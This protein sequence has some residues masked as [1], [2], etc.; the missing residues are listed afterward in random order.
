MNKIWLIMLIS[1]ISTL[2]FRNPAGVLEAVTAG[3]RASVELS[4]RLVALYAFW[5]G[6]FALLEKT[7]ITRKFARLLRP[8]VKFL[9]PK[10]NDESN[11]FITLNIS[12]N[13]LGIG[14]AAT[15]MA[16]RAINSM[17][18]KSGKATINMIMLVVISS[19][20]LQLLPSTL[21]GLRAEH[22]S[23]APA[24]FLA[25][26]LA[27]TIT[28]TIIGIT[29]VKIYGM[30]LSRIRKKKDKKGKYIVNAPL[31]TAVSKLEKQK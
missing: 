11:K 4:M 3:S 1:G 16:I 8:I 25:G 15:P 20:S 21:I 29:L 12:A 28:A 13:L 18:D 22:G 23:T 5:L 19:T 2:I 6:F 14:S 7:G 24:G 27:A 9:F 17:D 31:S 30:I 26:S 10:T